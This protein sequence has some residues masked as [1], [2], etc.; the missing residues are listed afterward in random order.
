MIE[1]NEVA[2]RAVL[3]GGG[4]SRGGLAAALASGALVRVRRDRYMRGDA[5]RAARDAVRIGGRLTCLSALQLF[6]VFVFSNSVTH[7]HIVRGMSRMRSAKTKAGAL[8]PRRKRPQRLHWLPLVRPHEAT[9]AQV[10]IVDALVPG[11]LCQEPRH[12]IATIDSALNK[13]L[14]EL[15]DLG[16]IFA[17][18]PRRFAVLR[19][20]VD[21]R[22]QSGPETLV[23]L[24]ARALG[25]RV[26]LQSWFEGVGFVDL[27]INGWLVIE[28]DSKEFHESW[29]Q[30][31]KDRNRDLALAALGYVTLRLTAAQIMYRP[32]EVRAAIRQLIDTHPGCVVR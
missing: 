27:V 15:A 4:I 2:T 1:H 5:L 25:C 10:G 19:A 11:V 17:A 12:A 31:V 14:I 28:C 26:E 6:G 16:D 23:R 18:L 29:E 8:E 20:L 21:G 9:D 3:L 22:A 24:M 13:G 32:D 7:V 30:Q